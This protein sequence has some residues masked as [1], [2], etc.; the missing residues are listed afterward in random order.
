MTHLTQINPPTALELNLRCVTHVLGGRARV[1]RSGGL[2]DTQRLEWTPSDETRYRREV[3]GL[4]ISVVGQYG[5]WEGEGAA[6][7]VALIVPVHG[8]IIE[9]DT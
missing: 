2:W 6:L 4:Q 1:H 3:A 9:S 7:C 5:T 8:C